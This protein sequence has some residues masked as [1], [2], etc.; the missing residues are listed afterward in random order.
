ME[1]TKSCFWGRCCCYNCLYANDTVMLWMNLL[2]SLMLMG[3]LLP[4]WLLVY[5]STFDRYFD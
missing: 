5:N 3:F 1:I 4:F 2:D